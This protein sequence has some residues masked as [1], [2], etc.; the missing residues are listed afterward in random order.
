MLVIY[1]T[2]AAFVIGGLVITMSDSFAEDSRS[3]Y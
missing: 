2:I 3:R 1:I